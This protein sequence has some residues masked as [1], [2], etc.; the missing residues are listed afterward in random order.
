MHGCNGGS[1][2]REREMNPPKMVGDDIS[3]ALY[4]RVARTKNIKRAK[5]GH[6]Q[7]Q[8]TLNKNLIKNCNFCSDFPKTGL[9]CTILFNIQKRAKRRNLLYSL[10]T[11]YIPGK[12]FQKGQ[13]WLIWPLATLL[14]TTDDDTF[15]LPLAEI[16]SKGFFN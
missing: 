4:S 15:N 8:E 12:Q 16:V 2:A 13:I 7:L 1:M 3:V 5:F 14:C 11:L 10:Y 6:K 9:K